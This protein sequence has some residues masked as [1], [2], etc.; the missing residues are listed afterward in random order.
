[1]PEL[2]EQR[3][4]RPAGPAAAQAV[5]GEVP[6]EAAGAHGAAEPADLGVGLEQRDAAAGP[7]EKAGGGQP[8]DAG[9]DDDGVEAP[10]ARRA[11][12]H[13]G[14]PAARLAEE[15]QPVPLPRRDGRG[16][17]DLPVEAGLPAQDLRRA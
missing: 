6:G 17:V 10:G 3:G 1:M 8:G 5:E 12:A 16:R 15:L 4:E 7:R 14:R 2:L 9:A 13:R 11:R